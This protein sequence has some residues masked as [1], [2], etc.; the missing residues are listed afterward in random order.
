LVLLSSFSQSV[1]P[2]LCSRK[3]QQI[4]YKETD[5]AHP[6]IPDVSPT[7]ETSE[8]IAEPVNTAVTNTTATNLEFARIDILS[9]RLGVSGFQGMLVLQDLSNNRAGKYYLRNLA[10]STQIPLNYFYCSTVSPNQ[11]R[12]ICE[13][14]DHLFILDNYQQIIADTNWK[15][16]WGLTLGWL[17]NE[18]ILL[19]KRAEP[20]APTIIYNPF[21]DIEQEIAPDYPKI[22]RAASST[23]FG[24][25]G[26]TGTI[27]DPSLEFVVYPSN[28]WNFVLWDRNKKQAVAE[29]PIRMINPNP[30]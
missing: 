9:T 21:K 23:I 5:T 22:S 28:E 24:Y 2:V 11:D 12:L 14:E 4:N 17:D 20:L 15:K 7:T 3:P 26:A 25:L 16:Q 27:Y 18:L 30:Q 6:P 8:P 13:T 1:V 10:T 29:I 19:T